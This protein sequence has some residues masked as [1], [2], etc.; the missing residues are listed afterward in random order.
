MTDVSPA[1]IGL[2]FDYIGE[3]GGYDENVLPS[4]QLVADDLLDR[5]VLE[6]PVEFVVRLVQGLP[7]G[8]FRAVRDAFFELVEEDALVIFGPWVSE[9]GAALRP[10]VEELGEVAC[11]TMGGTETMLG[12]WV[13]GLPAGSLE[14]EPIIM[15]TVAK[16][17]GCR[18][19]GIAYEDSLIGHEYLR[20]TRAACADAGL[21]ITG[22]VPI[23]QVDAEKQAAMKILAADRPDAIVHV[24]F[25]LGLIGMNEALEAIGWMPPRYTTTAFEFS[26]TSD[27][28][29]QQLAGWIGLDQYDERNEVARWLPRPVRGTARSPTRLLLPALLLRRRSPDDARHRQRPPVDRTRREGHAR[30]DQD[31]PGGDRR[32][33]DADAVR[34]LHPQRLGR[35]RV[36]GRAARPARRESQRPARHHRRSARGAGTAMTTTPETINACRSGRRARSGSGSSAR[37]STGPTSSSSG[38][39]VYDPAKVGVDAGTLVGR[40]PTGVA[41]T[42]DK[43]AILALD[44]DVV[45]HAASKA[46]AENTNTDDIVALLASGKSVITTTSYS[47]LPTYG[48]DADQRIRA[49]VRASRDAVPRRPANTPG[50]CSNGSRPR[51]PR[52]RS[53]STRSP[54]RSSS[55]AP[56][57]PAR[58]CSST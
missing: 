3:D 44:A 16:L 48:A 25:G 32:A 8:S 41:A 35:E 14:E 45:L 33:G 30:A 20:S 49:V 24:G 23:P 46:F 36:P 4:L 7:N 54:C 21:E 43:S 50:S 56:A 15:A 9:N 27:W 31:A 37:S 55:T 22:E 58:R 42:N 10:Y 40:A 38:L 34:P 11:I 26:A 1:R 13:F 17:D 51:S 6:R 5:G 12:E 19:V 52:S 18:S 39:F 47:H 28:W 57:C 53:G 2:L 29:R